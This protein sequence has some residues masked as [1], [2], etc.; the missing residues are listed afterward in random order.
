MHTKQLPANRFL[1]AIVG[2]GNCL[3]VFHNLFSP[4]QFLFKLPKISLKFMFTPA[5]KA[6]NLEYS[7]R[8]NQV[9]NGRYI[10][11]IWIQVNT[12]VL[13]CLCQGKKEKQFKQNAPRSLLKVSFYGIWNA[14]T[15]YKT[16]NPGSPIV[17]SNGQP[18]ECI[19]QFVD[20]HINP[21]VA[22]LDSHI[23]D[24]TD[25]LNKLA[26]LATLPNNAILVTLDVSSC[27]QHPTPR[28]NWYLPSFPWCS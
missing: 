16:G 18:T 2:S 15:C 8:L 5:S 23:K 17:S 6:E 19:S 28:R 13:T 3:V 27:F 1:G 22:L 21:P 9:F 10:H 24:T 25:F 11:L 14:V 26:N 20:F 4:F 12:R 7:W